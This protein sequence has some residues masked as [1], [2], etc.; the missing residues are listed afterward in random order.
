MPKYV[1]INILKMKLCESSYK[2]TIFAEFLKIT[3]LNQITK[4]H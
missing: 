4:Q 1:S 3:S 2:I